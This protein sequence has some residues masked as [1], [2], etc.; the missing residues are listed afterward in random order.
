M[1]GSNSFNG[2]GSNH[3]WFDGTHYVV[4]EDV[5]VLV[6]RWCLEKNLIAPSNEL[7]VGLRAK[8]KE[9]LNEIF[10][11]VT[12]VSSQEIRE[13]LLAS[14]ASHRE[15]GLT[16][17]SLERAYLEDNEVDGRIEIT[18]TVDGD[19]NDIL[20]PAKRNNCTVSKLQQF[21]QLRDKNIA[22]IDDVVFSGKTLVGTI[23]ELHHY[24]T[25]VHAVTAAIGAKNGIDHLSNARFRV[26]GQ[27]EQIAV[28]CLE[29]FDSISDQVC[30]RDFYPGVPYSGREHFTYD[31]VSFPYVLPF[32]KPQKWAS[33]PEKEVHQFSSLCLDNTITLFEEIERINNITISCSAVPRPVFG[34]PKDGTRFVTFLKE[35]R[36]QLSRS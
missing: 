11:R 10:A 26:I 29:E 3:R 24:N 7:Y 30:E 1:N 5:D 31:N 21:K 22:L 17:I 35:R 34:S 9:F 27:P 15:A 8:M 32:G 6:A 12:F 4:S 18:R 13:G 23:S 20:V 19:C 28:H 14:V 25:N 33:I 16:I 36:D 2:N